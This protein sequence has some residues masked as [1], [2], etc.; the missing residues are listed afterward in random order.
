MQGEVLRKKERNVSESEEILG[1]VHGDSHHVVGF[2]HNVRPLPAQQALWQVIQRIDELPSS[3]NTDEEI[4]PWDEPPRRTFFV[5]GQ[6]HARVY[7]VPLNIE[8][9]EFPRFKGLLNHQIIT[10]P[11]RQYRQL[12][13][14]AKIRHENIMY[15]LFHVEAGDMLIS[16]DHIWEPLEFPWT[17]WYVF[18]HPV[19]EWGVD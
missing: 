13:V 15:A 14:Y 2:T 7:Y 19:P 16:P 18:V 17:G 4:H 10:S 12:S 6:G 3:K 8:V 11:Q 9:P 1:Y 5:G